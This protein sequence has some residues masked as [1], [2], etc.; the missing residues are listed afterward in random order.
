MEIRKICK[1]LILIMTKW[2]KFMNILK[3][4]YNLIKTRKI[5][6]IDKNFL[7]LAKI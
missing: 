7:I 3:Y 6:K 4:R 5:D 1:I 2:Q